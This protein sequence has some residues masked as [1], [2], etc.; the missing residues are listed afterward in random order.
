MMEVG[1][2]GPQSLSCARHAGR[3]TE[4]EMKRIS[5]ISWAAWSTWAE[6]ALGRLSKM[7]IVFEFFI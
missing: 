4:K 6:I 1:C 3:P 2:A 7:K 5:L